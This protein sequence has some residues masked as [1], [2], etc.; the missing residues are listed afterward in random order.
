MR[1]ARYPRALRGHWAKRAAGKAPKQDALPTLHVGQDEVIVIRPYEA[2]P[3]EAEPSPEA[4][5]IAIEQQP[6]NRIVVSQR[7]THPHPFV[8]RTAARCAAQR[9][10]DSLRAAKKATPRA[11]EVEAPK[12]GGLAVVMAGR[13]AL[14]VTASAEHMMPEIDILR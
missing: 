12:T 5:E 4:P 7:L 9:V 14:Y 2:P 8:R 13:H 11:T 10:R 6:E 3:P 1:T